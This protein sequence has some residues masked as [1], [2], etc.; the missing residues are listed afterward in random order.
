VPCCHCGIADGNVFKIK[1]GRLAKGVGHAEALH[2]TCA[3]DFFTG[4]PSSREPSAT[5]D[6][7]DTISPDEPLH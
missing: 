2:E 7:D 5:P 6:L 4:K 3:K 1:D